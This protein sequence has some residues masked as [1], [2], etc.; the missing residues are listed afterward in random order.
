ML[1]L[2]NRLVISH[3][4]YKVSVKCVSSQLPRNLGIIL[5][6]QQSKGYLVYK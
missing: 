2:I 4:D 5:S 3:L 1:F 6:N